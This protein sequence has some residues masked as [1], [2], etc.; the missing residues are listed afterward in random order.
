MVFLVH[1][2]PTWQNFHKQVSRTLPVKAIPHLF[3]FRIPSSQHQPI[4]GICISDS[5]E[6]H[7][8]L[9]TFFLNFSQVQSFLFQQF[10]VQVD[11][12]I[13]VCFHILSFAVSRHQVHIEQ[14]CT[15]VQIK[16]ARRNL[17]QSRIDRFTIRITGRSDAQQHIVQPDFLFEQ[18]QQFPDILV[19]SHISILNLHCAL[20]HRAMRIIA[21]I[22]RQRQ[23]IRNFILAQ[24]LFVQRLGS[25]SID[26]AVY[27]RGRNKT[28]V[29][30]QAFIVKLVTES[31][32]S[33]FRQKRILFF[34]Q[35]RFPHDFRNTQIYRKTVVI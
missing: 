20:L 8:E 13:M 15:A 28:L 7:Q 31:F 24:Q 3:N 23:E 5:A 9:S 18:V 6:L 29:L 1:D 11:L 19:Q 27:K 26:L 16:L 33:P 22:I 21:C 14:S 35:Q 32:A 2:A 34:R 4:T 30:I 12:Q 10:P 17:V 25:Q